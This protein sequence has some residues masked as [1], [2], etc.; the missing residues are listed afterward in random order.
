MRGQLERN[1][2]VQLD[3]WNTPA[4]W[5]DHCAVPDEI[6]VAETPAMREA[7]RE[8]YV[9]LDGD[10]DTPAS[11]GPTLV[12]LRIYD[13]GVLFSLDCLAAGCHIFGIITS[14]QRVPRAKAMQ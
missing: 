9:Y 13:G 2:R 3:L 1:V 6:V 14:L 11:A 7:G 12:H 10:R 4:L 8:V 5:A